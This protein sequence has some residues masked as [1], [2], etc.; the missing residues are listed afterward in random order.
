L[1]RRENTGEIYL[2]T[3]LKNLL[4]KAEV[5]VTAVETRIKFLN[6]NYDDIFGARTAWSLLIR[7]FSIS[8]LEI[9][10]QSL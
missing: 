8:I 10:S 6:K 9:I 4:I 2:D 1:I 3:G 5:D 7:L